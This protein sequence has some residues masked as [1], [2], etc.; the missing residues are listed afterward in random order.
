MIIKQNN[1]CHA[2]IH[3][4]AVADAGGNA[5]PVQ[6]TGFAAG[7]LAMTT[8]TMNLAAVFGRNIESAVARGLAISA[9]KKQICK[10]PIKYLTKALVKY[11]PWGGP[12]AATISLAM[13]EAAGWCLANEFDNILIKFK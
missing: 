8:M 10:G 7:I 2:I 6:G 12:A 11:V 9:L 4:C 5:I 1:K 13:M 3:S